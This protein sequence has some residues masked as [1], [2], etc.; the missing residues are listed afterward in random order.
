MSSTLEAWANVQRKRWKANIE[1][2]ETIND[3]ARKYPEPLSKDIAIITVTITDILVDLCEHAV[4]MQKDMKNV[5]D[6]LDGLD[7][8]CA[9]WREYE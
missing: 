5:Q 8:D 4:R 1:D 2:L 9:S 6:R 7:D 3:L